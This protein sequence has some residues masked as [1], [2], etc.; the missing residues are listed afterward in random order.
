MI[1]TCICG[2]YEFEVK[3]NELP[4]EGRNVQCGV[5][6]KKWFQTPFEKKGKMPSSN[7]THYFAYLFLMLLIAISFVGVM[8]TFRE[9]LVYNFPKIDQYYKFI[10]NILENLLDELNY[11]F[12]SFGF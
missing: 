6:N 10:E 11:L 12:R 2:K 3:K 9:I 4:K 1:I 8:E 5:C 7:T